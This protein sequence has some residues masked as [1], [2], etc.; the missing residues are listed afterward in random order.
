MAKPKN[1]KR[2]NVIVRQ[3]S[4]PQP[5]QINSVLSGSN[6]LRFTG[7]AQTYFTAKNLCDTLI[8]AV[9]T[10]AGYDIMQAIRL[11]KIESFAIS[12]SGTPVT[13]T[14]QFFD[15][16]AGSNSSTK[17][18]SDTSLGTAAP[19]HVVAR[20]PA[21]STAGL[22]QSYQSTETLF[23]LSASAASCVIDIEFEYVLFSEGNVSQASSAIAGTGVPGV[24]YG[25]GLDGLAVAATA[26]P[27]VPGT[28][29]LI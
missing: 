13:I 16:T 20:P 1:Q 4:I 19:A 12:S 15:N 22:W 24:L 29:P 11:K 23:M 6:T 5:K 3:P 25:R 7:T 28:Y 18:F 9:S 21:K 26:Y 17:V 10:I 8:V 14:I 2:M 27:M